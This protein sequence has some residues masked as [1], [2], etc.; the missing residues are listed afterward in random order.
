[1]IYVSE[2]GL[3]GS[4]TWNSRKYGGI[5]VVVDFFFIKKIGVFLLSL[6]LPPFFDPSP[7][8]T[9]SSLLVKLATL[10]PLV[11]PD[12]ILGLG[13]RGAVAL[14]DGQLDSVVALRG[15][16]DVVVVP[17]LVEDGAS[18]VVGAATGLGLVVPGTAAADKGEL[19]EAGGQRVL[20]VGEGV[21]GLVGGGDGRLLEPRVRGDIAVEGDGGLEI[22]VEISVAAGLAALNFSYILD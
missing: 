4:F 21:G 11:V 2:C 6:C 18:G 8:S 22:L 20:D 9:T 12:G 16:V 10:S 1:M 5:T 15:A 3:F 19:A 14:E 13:A 17:D 7:D